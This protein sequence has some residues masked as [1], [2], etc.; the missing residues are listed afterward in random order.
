TEY[1]AQLPPRD[2]TIAAI[3]ETIAREL[4][5]ATTTGYGPRFLHST[6]QLHKGGADNGVFIQMSGGAGDDIAIPGEKYTFG[7][8][9]R[10]QAIGDYV[11]LANRKRRLVSDNLGSHGD[12][13]LRT[14][15]EPGKKPRANPQPPRSPM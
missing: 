10:A 5:V 8:L 14:L 12:L 11:S 7:A 4:H 6:G 9:C 1:V 3:R 2:K 15:H 13:R